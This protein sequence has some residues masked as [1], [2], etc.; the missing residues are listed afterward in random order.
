M[1]LSVIA[2]YFVG[3]IV[4]LGIC[5]IIAWFFVEVLGGILSAILENWLIVLTAIIVVPFVIYWLGMGLGK[6]LEL[7]KAPPDYFKERL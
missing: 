5:G 2:A 7:F 1:I 6:F 3:K 4:G